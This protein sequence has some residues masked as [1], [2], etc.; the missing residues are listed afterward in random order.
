[1]GFIPAEDL[2]EGDLPP[3]GRS[4]QGGSTTTK[5]THGGRPTRRRWTTMTRYFTDCREYPSEMG[6]T[7]AIAADSKEELLEAAAHHAV[8]VHGHEDDAELRENLSQMIH[9]GAP[10]A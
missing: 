1:M 5:R 3:L 6:C 7:V 4:G 2:S 10:P 8:Q 9:E